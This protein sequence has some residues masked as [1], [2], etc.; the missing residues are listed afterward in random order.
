[1]YANI[2]F[3]IASFQSFIYKIPHNLKK[4]IYVGCPVNVPFKNKII[5]GYVESI[6]TDTH[7]K[8]KIYSIDSICNDS[9]LQLSN[10]LWKTIVWMSKYYVSP[11]GLCI[12][13][14]IPSIFL[15]K[16]N[17]QKKIFI[18]MNNRQV[19][20]SKNIK[21]SKNQQKVVTYLINSKIP[22]PIKLLKGYISNIYD[23]INRLE[24]KGLIN[25]IYFDNTDAQ[26]LNHSLLS[27]S[28]SPPQQKVFDKIIPY[29][30]KKKY[31]G[32]L[33]HGVPGSGKTEIYIKLAQDTIKQGKS[34]IVLIPEIILTTQMKN[35]FLKYFGNS[36]AVWHSKMSTNEK[37]LTLKRIKNGKHKI[38]IG[39]RSSIFTSLLNIGLIII[40]EEQD[41][42]Y[43]QESPKPYYN[44]RDV[45]FMRAL[46][47]KCPIV[48]TSA[49]PSIEMYYNSIIDKIDIIELQQTYYQSK[50]PKIQV[51]NMLDLFKNKGAQTIISQ[52]LIQAIAKTLKNKGQCIVLNNRRGYATSVFSKSNNNSISCDFCNV[53]MS[54]HKSTNKLLCHYCDNHKTFLKSDINNL[55]DEIILNGYGTEK[56]Q[57]I[58]NN[59]FPSNSIERIDSDTLRNKS[60]LH[61]LLSGFTNGEIDILIG[62]QM[63]SKGL[64]FDNVQ[65]VGVINAD[66]GMFIPDFR[67]GEKIFQ[68]ISQVIG[69]TGRRKKQGRAIIQTYNP[70]NSNLIN[71]IQYNIKTF[72]STNLAERNELSYPPFT[73]MCRITFSGLN[74]EKVERISTKITNLFVNSNNF[75]VLGPAEAP[76][77]KIKN[78]WRINSLIMAD[79]KNAMEIQD[80]FNLNIGT[81]YLEKEYKTVK[82]RLD[83]DPINML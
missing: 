40:D 68:I 58:L 36:V 2:V 25:K 52:S 3:P 21:L 71:A 60:I 80:F 49:T 1:M 8:G 62:T 26:L 14:A 53:P 51:V 43:K 57:E 55:S 28:L 29:I 76:I 73:R 12:K 39:A 32:F 7:Y 18:T 82:I 66:Y 22:T 83:I 24:K 4:D 61:S 35:R 78:Q 74:L 54:F 56:I 30:N 69:R 63:L 50:P 13:S 5:L 44:A 42:S 70:D 17:Q 34:V 64:D 81:K 77:S 75:K 67:S 19:I 11:I 33:I 15:K 27:P 72:Y 9:Q 31:H 45:G 23:V 46:Y 10:N 6:S 79:K 37:L 48:L 65:L 38:I 41:S 47:S 16:F 20:N 59:K